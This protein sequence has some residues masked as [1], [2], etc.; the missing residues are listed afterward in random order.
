[1]NPIKNANAPRRTRRS[2]NIRMLTASAALPDQVNDPQEITKTLKQYKVVPY[3]GIDD[4]TGDALL[5][6]YLMLGRMSPTHAACIEKLNKYAFGTGRVVRAKDPDFETGEEDSPTTSAEAKAYLENL[7]KFIDF[8]GTAKSLHL[9][10]GRSYKRT[11]GAWVELSFARALNQARCSVK[12]HKPR[13][14]RFKKTKPGEMKW[15]FVSPLWTDK[16]LKENPPREVPIYPNFVKGKDGVERTMFYLKHGDGDWYGRPDSEGS[17]LYKYYETQN[18]SYLI[19]TAAAGYMEQM[20]LEVEAEA[21]DEEEM[22]ATDAG[23]KSLAERLEENLSRQSDDPMGG[24]VFERAPGASPMAVVQLKPN[25]S[26]K[27][28]RS[29]GEDAAWHIVRSHGCTLRFLGFDAASGFSNDAFLSDYVINMEPVLQEYRNTV[30]GFVNR[31]LSACWTLLGLGDMDA[32]S[33]SFISPIASTV[34]QYKQAGM[35]STKTV[36]PVAKRPGN[37]PENEEEETP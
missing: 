11:G 8:Q 31:I 30:T 2:W 36:Q 12:Y 1:M 15:V 5:E 33:L 24:L 27:W 4:Q 21:I 17:D 37:N 10:I 26:D 18:S 23:F 7:K 34:E 6:W 28:F 9:N 22:A 14:V 19:K 25:T 35:K 13:N 32:F 29:T 20:L 3:A 16:H